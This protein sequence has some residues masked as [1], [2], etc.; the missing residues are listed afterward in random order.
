MKI[1]RLPTLFFFFLMIILLLPFIS[2]KASL[3]SFAG[4][5][6]ISNKTPTVDRTTT[7]TVFINIYDTYGTVIPYGT[8][9]MFLFWS[10]DKVEWVEATM[11]ASAIETYYMDIPAQDGSD[12]R[13]YDDGEGP[14]Y[15]YIMME[16]NHNEKDY[17]FDA[18]SPN[19]EIFFDNPWAEDTTAVNGENGGDQPFSLFESALDIV[20]GF[21]DPSTSPIVKISLLLVVGI[22][23]FILASGGRG[24]G[25]LSNALRGI[26][27]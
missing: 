5:Y 11:T 18:D 20:E 21:F 14:L 25:W 22:I 1:H 26:I 4:E 23:V 19:G 13:Q 6:L 2:V 9:S 17:F 12:N 15:W 27:R 8:L 16:N 3:P 24:M 10:R 7:V